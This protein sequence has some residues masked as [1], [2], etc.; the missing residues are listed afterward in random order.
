MILSSFAACTC[1]GGADPCSAA[2][3]LAVASA[4]PYR[5]WRIDL[6]RR[7]DRP[8]RDRA[9]VYLQRYRCALRR[10]ERAS[11][12]GQVPNAGDA[13]QL[14]V[15]TNL[16]ALAVPVSAG[17]MRSRVCNSTC[18]HAC[19]AKLAASLLCMRSV[20]TGICA[21]TL[22]RRHQQHYHRGSAARV[23]LVSVLVCSLGGSSNTDIVVV[24]QDFNCYLYW[25]AH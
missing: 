25:Y 23:Q 13:W 18:F 17:T 14:Q 20:S 3:S 12:P 11:F 7:T 19:L 22:T 6:C 2:T 24:P 5:S 8:A 15:C 16:D 4:G 9:G 10:R 21:G 1:A